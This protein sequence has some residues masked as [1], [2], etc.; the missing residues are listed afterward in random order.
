MLSPNGV[1]LH[2]DVRNDK[3]R[4][5]SQHWVL[6][7]DELDSRG[8]DARAAGIAGTGSETSVDMRDR[9]GHQRQ[10]AAGHPRPPL[11][12]VLETAGY[13]DSWALP[14][15]ASKMSWGKMVHTRIKFGLYHGAG[16]VLGELSARRNLWW[17]PET[18]C[19][20]ICHV[21]DKEL[22]AHV[23]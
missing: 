15:V 4:M 7:R 3:P 23:P 18:P 16:D 17:L 2:G 10:V 9:V 11:H 19:T 21:I 13:V 22:L 20:R 1:R 12:D 5:T 14:G 6:R 8:S